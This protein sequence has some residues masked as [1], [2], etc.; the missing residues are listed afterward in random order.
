MQVVHRVVFF[1]DAGGLLRVTSRQYLLRAV[2]QFD[3]DSS[4]FGEVAVDF[5]GQCVLRMAPAGD[6][7]DVQC[8]RPHP[9]DIR[10]DLDGADDRA[11]VAGD[12][13]LQGEQDE[14]ALLGL[15]R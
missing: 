3:C 15:E 1:A 14:R 4:H 8:Q 6:L 9:V 11:K 2:A 12:G 5:L 7:G 10:D 13:C